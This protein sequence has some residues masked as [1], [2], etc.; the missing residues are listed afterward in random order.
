MASKVLYPPIV[1]SYMPAFVAKEGAICRVYFSLS[2]FNSRSDFQSV[3]ISV[4]KQGSGA[5]VV[6]KQDAAPRYRITGII[7]NAKP[8]KVESNLYY[9]DILSEDVGKWEVGWIYKVQIR[10]SMVDYEGVVT[11]PTWLNANASNFSEWS[12]VCTIKTIGKNQ[13]TIPM[14]NYDNLNPTFNTNL[15]LN[16]STLNIT[17][18]YSNEDTSEMLY[19]YQMKLLCNNEVLEDSGVLYPNQYINANQFNYLFKRALE[20]NDNYTFLLEYETNNKYIGKCEI[21]FAAQNFDEHELPFTLLTAETGAETT[22]YEEEEEGRVGLQLSIPAGSSYFGNV[23]IRRS[24]ELNNYS[25]WEDIKILTFTHEELE[26]DFI[27]PVVY[28]YTATSGINYKY[29]IQYIN[30]Y[31][32]RGS[33][34]I[35]EEPIKREYQFSYLLGENE[36]QLKL[37]FDNSLSNYKRNVSDAKVDTI[38]GKHPFI[39]RNGNM[40]YKSFSLSGLISYNMDEANLFLQK[41]FIGR[42][43]EGLYDYTFEREFREEVLNFL[44]SDKP[45]LFKSP[46]EGNL[47]VRLMNVSTT[48]NKTL[49][50]MIYS[51]S[52][53][54]YEIAEPTLENYLEYGFTSVGEANSDYQNLGQSEHIGQYNQ[55]YRLGDNII[56]SICQKHNSKTSESVQKVVKITDLSITID[57]EPLAS[58]GGWEL[59]INGKKILMKAPNNVFEPGIEFTNED[60]V[61]IS[62]DPQ[63]KALNII[64]DYKYTIEEK[65]IV[66]KIKKTSSYIKTIGQICNTYPAGSVL[67]SS[68]AAKYYIESDSYFRYIHKFDKICIEAEPGTPF[69]IL[70]PDYS[71]QQIMVGDTGVLMIDHPQDIGEIGCYTNCEVLIDYGCQITQGTYKEE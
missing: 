68:I 12:T 28:D 11:Q 16:A 29:G 22:V 8:V 27:Y 21:D 15:I 57:D 33:L 50:R 45:K 49:N 40:N 53:E 32:M 54:G 65:R 4:T 42:E 41:D 36:Q 38:G 19:S 18:S 61:S 10:F 55:L 20:K 39:T 71:L 14:F 67:L 58:V 48:P 46:T 37:K 69:A 23:C 56:K 70:Y 47:L 31:D 66:H 52:A 9:V 64:V 25:D 60:V 5:S 3:H 63:I 26:E 44:Y 1:N 34:Q 17:G 2:K 7:L 30:E 35:I 59:N 51:F 62:P 43:A 13:I 6:K 24:S